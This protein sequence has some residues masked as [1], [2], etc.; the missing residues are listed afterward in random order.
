MDRGDLSGED[1]R[2]C[3]PLAKGSA[4]KEGRGKILA[5]RLL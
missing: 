4:E 2:I 5:L 3:L 1:G